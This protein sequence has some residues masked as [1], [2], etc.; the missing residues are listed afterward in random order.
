MI[1][2]WISVLKLVT[3]NSLM[4]KKWL[5][6][7]VY[8]MNY[9]ENLFHL[10]FWITTEKSEDECVWSSV[11]SHHTKRKRQCLWKLRK[12]R[13]SNFR[14]EFNDTTHTQYT[15]YKNTDVQP[16]IKC[17]QRKSDCK[18]ISF[19]DNFLQNISLIA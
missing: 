4:R 2:S 17:L 8:Q 9:S 19:N 13:M 18:I 15:F 3:W 11:Y 14:G 6:L 10:S 1:K 12:L 5:L 7:S 16:P